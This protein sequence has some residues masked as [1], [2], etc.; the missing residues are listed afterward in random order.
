MQP[1]LIAIAL[2]ALAAFAVVLMK[3]R[4]AQR[5]LA[6]S[7]STSTGH[8]DKLEGLRKELGSV[9]EELQRKAKALE[10]A[11]EEARKRARREGKK[12]KAEDEKDAEPKDDPRDAEIARLKKAIGAV[13]Q[14]LSQVKASADKELKAARDEARAELEGDL[15]AKADEVVALKRTLDELR[16]SIKRKAEERPNVPGTTLD[17][18]ALPAEAVQELAR[19]FRKAEEFE[20]LYAIAQGKVQLASERQQELQR[21]YYAVCRELAVAA[22][23]DAGSSDEEVRKLAESLVAKSDEAL[24][25][26]APESAQAA[27]DSDGDVAKKKKRRRRKKRKPGASAAEGADAAGEDGDGDEADEGDDDVEDAAEASSASDESVSDEPAREQAEAPPPD[28]AQ[29]PAEASASNEAPPPDE[30]ERESQTVT[31]A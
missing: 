28:E 9:K 2:L 17:L 29:P 3:L 1:A 24:A 21:R 20:R 16:E 11:R 14:Q 8:E 12:A 18:K 15:K 31:E 25:G 10:E 26:A 30:P 6:E 4:D 27:A 13:E 7:R 22:G 23:N 5:R 19:Y